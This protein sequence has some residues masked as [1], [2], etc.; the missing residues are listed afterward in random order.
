MIGSL[1]CCRSR[2]AVALL[3]L[4]RLSTRTSMQSIA[5]YSMVI[6][7]PSLANV[8]GATFHGKPIMLVRAPVERHVRAVGRVYDR[9]GPADRQV[10]PALSI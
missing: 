1:G 8:H 2:F 4:R 7:F 3:G 10:W 6:C 9:P 5:N